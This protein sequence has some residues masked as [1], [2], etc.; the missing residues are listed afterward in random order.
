MVVRSGGFHERRNAGAG[1]AGATPVLDLLS[2]TA[3]AAWSVR[4]VRSAYAGNCIKVRRSSDNAT[5]NI[6]FVAGVL[7]TASMLTFVGAGN[8]FI[9]TWYDQSGN[10][11]NATQATAANQPR[12]VTSGALNT[13]GTNSIAA[14]LFISANSTRLGFSNSAGTSGTGSGT[15]ST[16]ARETI[17]SGANNVGPLGYGDTGT[18]KGRAILAMG[19][20]GSPLTIQTAVGASTYGGVAPNAA[21]NLAWF[22]HSYSAI[23]IWSGSGSTVK[24]YVNGSENEGQAVYSGS[25]N[26]TF[27]SPQNFIGSIAGTNYFD[28]PIAETLLFNSAMGSTDMSTLVS[29]QQSYFGF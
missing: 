15:L 24:V 6:G 23:C 3:N 17:S 13:F 18:D 11:Y 10:G 4:K 1:G 5:Q 7:D 8:G 20:I 28:G 21:S 14:P 12:I 19:T 25:F 9:D 22:N 16:A 27:T 2:I 29:N 26:T